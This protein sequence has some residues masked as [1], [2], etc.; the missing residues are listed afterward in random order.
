M[1]ILNQ[2]KSIYTTLD[3]ITI[4]GSANVDKMCGCFYVLTQ[5]INELEKQGNNKLE[6]QNALVSSTE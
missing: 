4:S 3:T 2:L 6:K 1:D 5:V